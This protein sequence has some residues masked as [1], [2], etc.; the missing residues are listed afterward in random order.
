MSELRAEWFR[1]EAVSDETAAFN[2][3]LEKQFSAS[4]HPTTRSVQER[5]DSTDALIE[6][7]KLEFAEERPLGPVPSRILRPNQVSAVFLWF[8]PGGWRTGRPW[9]NEH[10][11]WALAESS[12]IA[13]VSVG[14]RL[15]P[16][17][18]YPAAP[19]DCEAAALWLVTNARAEFGTDRIVIGGGSAGA[20]LA[21]V[22]L[23]RLRDRHGYTGFF[24]A[25]LVYGVFDAGGT[26][27]MRTVGVTAPAWDW[28]TMQESAELYAPGHD[29]RDPEISP[30]YG[31][32][33]SMPPALFSVGSRDSLLEDTLFM[34]SRWLAAGNDADL[35]VYPGGVHG[36]DMQPLA[37]ARASV[38]RRHAWVRERLGLPAAG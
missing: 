24:G 14:Y 25:D 26:P 20:N 1:P 10:D 5:R 22:V 13:T 37:I 31:D 3:N 32:L 36:F 4:P 16:E 17:H 12:G 29:L 34:H 33:R 6:R 9:M 21:A 8:H 2:A 19:D 27:W 28:R 30:L 23:G 38:A 35:A 11:L 7:R 18:P 15:A